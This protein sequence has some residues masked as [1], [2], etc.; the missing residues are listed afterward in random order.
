MP[1]LMEHMSL[2]RKDITGLGMQLQMPSGNKASLAIDFV[3]ADEV[4]PSVT[5]IDQI[6]VDKG[7]ILDIAALI[8]EIEA[9]AEDA[10]GIKEVRLDAARYTETRASE[11]EI[12][13]MNS[14]NW[15]WR[16]F[17]T[18]WKWIR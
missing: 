15:M 1:M 17:R 16:T 2:K 9:S 12:S 10:S 6:K 13:A 14:N 5:P 18:H 8:D 4:A 11:E 3:V 7:D